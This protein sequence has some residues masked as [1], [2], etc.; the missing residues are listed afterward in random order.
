MAPK[1]APQS[2]FSDEL[3]T[4]QISRAIAYTGQPARR[5]DPYGFTSLVPWF[6]APFWWLLA[7]FLLMVAALVVTL[8]VEVPI[9]N[10]IEVW[11]ATTLPADWRSIQTR[12]AAD[13]SVPP[14]L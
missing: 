1:P 9:D 7:G 10:R 3:E 2:I 13:P 8:A 12:I 4:T 11:T 5:G 14:R 6:T